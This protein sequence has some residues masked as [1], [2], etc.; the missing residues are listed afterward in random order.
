MVMMGM[1]AVRARLRLCEG[2]HW[3]VSRVEAICKRLEFRK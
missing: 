3:T 1:A 2:R